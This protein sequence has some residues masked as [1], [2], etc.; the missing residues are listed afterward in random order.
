[1]RK[2]ARGDR[3]AIPH[4]LG[5]HMVA[6]RYGTTPAAVRQW[7]AIDYLEALAMLGATG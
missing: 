5:I 7:P 4:Q 3:S 1:V 2:L 6:A